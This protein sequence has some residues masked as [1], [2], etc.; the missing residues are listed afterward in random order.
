MVNFQ[1]SFWKS[2]L[3]DFTEIPFTSYRRITRTLLDPCDTPPQGLLHTH[4]HI[5]GGSFTSRWGRG[6]CW[7]VWAFASTW[8]RRLTWP[9]SMRE[10]S[11]RPWLALT[12]FEVH[13]FLR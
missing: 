1:G 13:D 4:G 9:C 2:V 10:A 3:G 8:P 5:S 11:H 7:H 6:R 12:S